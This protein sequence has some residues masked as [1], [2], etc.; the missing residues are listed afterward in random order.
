MNWGTISGDIGYAAECVTLK[1]CYS[2][3]DH[4]PPCPLPCFPPNLSPLCHPK[5]ENCRYMAALCMHA[6]GHVDEATRCYDAL[7]S[8]KPGHQAWYTRECCV[9]LWSN[10]RRP[11]RD[12]SADAELDPEFKVRK[13]ARGWA[14]KVALI[15]VSVLHTAV[16]AVGEYPHTEPCIR[17]AFAPA[18]RLCSS[19]HAVPCRTVP[20]VY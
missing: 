4:I 15:H 1:D 5:D 9:Y 12:F 6:R 2:C 10:I 17:D 8:L 7:L 3:F 13:G 18:Q 16:T 19:C 14:T 11:W 20:C